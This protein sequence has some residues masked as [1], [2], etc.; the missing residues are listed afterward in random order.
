MPSARTRSLTGCSPPA[1]TSRIWRRRGSATALNASAVVAARAMPRSYIHIGIRQAATRRYLRRM[2]VRITWRQALAWRMQRQML[3]PPGASPVAEV[4]SRLCGVQ[5]QVASSAELA[6]RVRRRAS[7]PG[8][9]DRALS[10]GRLIKTWAMRGAL[11]LLPPEEAGMFLS[12]LA[13]DRLWASW[14]RYFGVSTKQMAVLRRAIRAA[15]EGAPLTRVE[16]AEAVSAQRGLR[17]V[18]EALRS[19]WGELLKPLAWQGDVCFGP[20]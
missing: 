1:S 18:G 3:D 17:Q 15:L 11:H 9:V 7:Q 8:E 14:Q 10:E 16:L 5:A 20:S 4:V 19:G 2:A 6:V 12:L 13:A